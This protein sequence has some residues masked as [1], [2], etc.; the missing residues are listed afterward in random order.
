MIRLIMDVTLLILAAEAAVVLA[1]LVLNLPVVTIE[2]KVVMVV[3]VLPI[4]LLV[5]L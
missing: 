5:H 3:M 4:Q 1:Q 2:A